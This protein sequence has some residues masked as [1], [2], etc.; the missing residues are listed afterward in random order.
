MSDVSF[1]SPCM[2]EILHDCLRA[3]HL[4]GGADQAVGPLHVHELDLSASFASAAKS[5][6]A[7]STQVILRPRMVG[8]ATLR[9]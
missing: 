9:E 2:H 7:R 8:T 5:N 4:L 1:M 6:V 3:G